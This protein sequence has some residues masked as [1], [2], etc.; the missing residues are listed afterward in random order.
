MK[1]N[2]TISTSTISPAMA[3]LFSTNTSS[4]RSTRLR[5]LPG[6]AGPVPGPGSGS[7]TMPPNP[8]VSGS[9]LLVMR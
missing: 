3:S 8:G 1:Q 7:V 2:P 4:P 5:G 9:S 6:R